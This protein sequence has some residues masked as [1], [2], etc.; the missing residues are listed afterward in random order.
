MRYYQTAGGVMFP[1]ASVREQCFHMQFVVNAYGLLTH[2][3]YATFPQ[4]LPR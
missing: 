1:A 2:A 3:R 4:S